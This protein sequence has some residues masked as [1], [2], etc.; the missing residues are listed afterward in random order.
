MNFLTLSDTEILAIA[1]PMMD[2]LMDAS[3]RLDHAAHVRDFTDR[4]KAIV[5][6]EHLEYVCRQYQADKGFFTDR[7]AV[8]VFKRPDSAAVV[9]K[10]H[11]SKAEGDYVAEM[12]LVH[13]EGRYLIDHV[14]VF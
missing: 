12:M 5:T 2:H 9:W 1:N 8:A 4:I 13:R 14:M 3:T 7:T 10:Q 6:P 11:F